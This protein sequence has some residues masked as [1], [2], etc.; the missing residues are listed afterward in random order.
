MA[1]GR[2]KFHPVH[3]FAAFDDTREVSM[4]SFPPP[5]EVQSTPFE[6]MEADSQLNSFVL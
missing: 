2:F 5:Y 6:R 4:H 3:G 1:L